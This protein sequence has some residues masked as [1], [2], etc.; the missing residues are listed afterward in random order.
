MSIYTPEFQKQ[1]DGS[2]CAG[3]NCV[4]AAGSMA[5]NCNK[6]KTETTPA[7]LRLLSGDPCGGSDAQRLDDVLSKNFPPDQ[8]GTGWFSPVEI[9]NGVNL[10]H[11]AFSAQVLYA[12]IADAGYPY[13]GQ[14]KGFRGWHE[15][16]ILPG[17][18]VMDPL[19]DGRRPTVGKSPITYPLA[20]MDKVMRITAGQFP[21]GKVHGSWTLP[22]DII[23]PVHLRYGGT[24]TGRHEYTTRHNARIRSGPFV[25]KA[26]PK[27]NLV[28]W[29]PKG[30][31][32][33]AAQT[34]K[35]GDDIGPAGHTWYGDATGTLWI[36][37]GAVS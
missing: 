1:L 26:H 2:P 33:H 22:L 21:N 19:A 29:L 17:N 24:D 28:R 7:Q 16:L 11:K 12:P 15:I 4:F 10:D 35:T 14:E 8:L 32:F 27:S 18:V 23:V 31:V 25:F 20:L 34:T 3:S 5:H 37:A 36:Y 13:S 9:K 6:R 30:A